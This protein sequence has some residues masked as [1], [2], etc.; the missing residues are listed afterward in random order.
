MLKKLLATCGSEELYEEAMKE[1]KKARKGCKGLE[2][3]GKNH[4][5][6]AMEILNSI[7]DTDDNYSKIDSI[8]RC[9]K[10]SGVLSPTDEAPCLK[11]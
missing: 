7:W 1:D 8:R 11:R 6:D 2:Y 3:C 5:L 9:W 4:L 10:N